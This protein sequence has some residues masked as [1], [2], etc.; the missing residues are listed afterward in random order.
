MQNAFVCGRPAETVCN[1]NQIAK[2][3]P[4][5]DISQKRLQSELQQIID[6][7]HIVPVNSFLSELSVYASHLYF[8]PK[9]PSD[10]RFADEFN[11]ESRRVGNLYRRVPEKFGKFRLLVR[12]FVFGP[13]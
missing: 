9:G 4:E 3:L 12:D 7:G 13:I 1:G 6:R 2:D 10:D 5:H 8:N 11:P